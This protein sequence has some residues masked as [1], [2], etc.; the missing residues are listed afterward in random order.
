MFSISDQRN[1]MLQELPFLKYLQEM[2][3]AI[4]CIRHE[5]KSNRAYTTATEYAHHVIARY[6]KEY[7]LSW[8]NY[9]KEHAGQY[10]RLSKKVLDKYETKGSNKSKEY[11]INDFVQEFTYD[12]S[13]MIRARQRHAEDPSWPIM[14]DPI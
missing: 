5:K 12:M 13:N 7:H 8:D 14:D 1:M 10:L 9:H 2:H 6:I 4:E 11:V 3:D